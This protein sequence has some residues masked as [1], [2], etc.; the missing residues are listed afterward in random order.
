M[1]VFR[2]P[3]VRALAECFPGEVI[4]VTETKEEA[5]DLV[6]TKFRLR[7]A[8]PDWKDHTK[9]RKDITEENRLEK[10]LLSTEPEVHEL[11]AGFYI[12]GSQ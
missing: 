12:Y 4:A 5:I 7:Y 10:E 6:M 11:P 3:E 2:W 9:S 1:K 8:G